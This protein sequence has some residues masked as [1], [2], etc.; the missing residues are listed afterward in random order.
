MSEFTN[1]SG[2]LPTI[3]KTLAVG[4]PAGFLSIASTLRFRG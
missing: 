3:L 2:R 1:L 4:I